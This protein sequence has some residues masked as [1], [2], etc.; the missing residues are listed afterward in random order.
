MRQI[1]SENGPRK[2]HLE[3]ESYH[4]LRPE[5]GENFK[6]HVGGEKHRENKRQLSP[7]LKIA[8]LLGHF[9]TPVFMQESISIKRI[10]LRKG[11]EVPG[12]YQSMEKFKN[13]KK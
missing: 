10:K 9:Q 7:S 5:W 8:S 1:E 4:F 12:E 6:E 2:R 13:T 3:L 11:K